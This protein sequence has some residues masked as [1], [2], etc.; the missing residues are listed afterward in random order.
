M[1]QREREVLWRQTRL[2][3]WQRPLTP[4]DLEL[5]IR[6]TFARQ[7]AA[8]GRKTDMSQMPEAA[9]KDGSLDFSV[10]DGMQLGGVKAEIALCRLLGVEFDPEGVIGEPDVGG[11]L[12]CRSSA[13]AYPWLLVVDPDAKPK[14]LDGRI[15]CDL[16]FVLARATPSSSDPR[17]SFWGWAHG[18]DLYRDA[19]PVKR[20]GTSRGARYL[21]PRHLRSM[22]ALSEA[23]HKLRARIAA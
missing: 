11:C 4:E 1:D 5:A 10:L 22:E 17:V 14:G 18:W 7:S 21:P 6:A 2:P 13:A 15:P 12:E 8:R 16:P 19:I 9:L 3:V 23:F 20:W